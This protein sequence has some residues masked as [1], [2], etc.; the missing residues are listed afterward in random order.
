MDRFFFKKFL[1]LI[2]NIRIFLRRTDKV[3][4]RLTLYRAKTAITNDVP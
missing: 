3:K 2:N 4:S 1:D